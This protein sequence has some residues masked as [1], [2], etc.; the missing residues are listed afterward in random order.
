M[1]SIFHDEGETVDVT[2]TAAWTAGDIIQLPDGR[3]GQVTVSVASGKPVAVRVKQG[4]LLRSVTKTSGFNALKGNPAFWDFSAGAV[5]YK[6]VNDQD[7]FIGV[8]TDDGTAAGTDTTCS[9]ALNVPFRTDIDLLRDGFLSVPTGTQA[10]G[11]TG[12]GLPKDFGGSKQLLITATNEAQCIDL[13]SVDRFSVD[14]NFMAR[15]IFRPITNGSDS[16][17]DFDIGVAGS[18]DT[19]NGD[20]IAEQALVHIDGGSTNILSQ[21][22]DGTTDTAPDAT[23]ST[24]SAGSAVANRTEVWIDGRDK[25]AIKFYIDG[26]LKNNDVNHTLAAAVGP[27]G[28]LVLLEKTT[29]TATANFIIDHGSVRFQK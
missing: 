20:D 26:A 12:F 5:N 4:S 15:F 1:K 29:G 7:F 17:V 2:S 21:S 23:G 3:A 6:K 9:I 10:A 27:L 22:D 16:T 11:S 14:S 24:I 28:L 19:D 25:T 8:F 13:F 18:T